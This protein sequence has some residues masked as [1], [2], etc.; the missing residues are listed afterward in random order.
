V[1][2]AAVALLSLQPAHAASEKCDTTEWAFGNDEATRSPSGDVSI[3]NLKLSQCS[4]LLQASKADASGL[5]AGIGN[6]T[7]KLTGK[8]HLEFDGAVFD[9]D[10]ATIVLVDGRLGSVNVGSGQAQTAQ[11]KIPVHVEFNGAVLAAD[12]AAATFSAGRIKT[13]QALGA[14]VQFSF[15]VKKSGQ[16]V[17]GSSPRIDY[18]AD[19]T[20]ISFIEAAYFYGSDEVEAQLLTY[21]FTDGSTSTRKAI[22]TYRPD[23]RV[24]APRTPDRATAK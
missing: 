9:S 3:T 16:R 4:T 6:T 12:T 2:A 11:T 10:T 21:N 5:D 14:P 13:I 19:K 15:Q 8:V 17:H 24:P 18:D 23:E 1:L 20:L 22:G 7:W